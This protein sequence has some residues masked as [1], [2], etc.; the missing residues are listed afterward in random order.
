MKHLSSQCSQYSRRSQYCAVVYVIK[1]EIFQKKVK[2][3]ESF[4]LLYIE[5]KNW[6]PSNL[7]APRIYEINNDLLFARGNS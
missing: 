5:R 1:D 6:R 3:F 4:Y 2:P 7:N